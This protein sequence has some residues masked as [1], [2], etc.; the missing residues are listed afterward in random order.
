MRAPFC[1]LRFTVCGPIYRLSLI[2]HLEVDFIIYAE[3]LRISRKKISRW[4]I[5]RGCFA[6]SF[7]LLYQLIISFIFFFAFPFT[8]IPFV[9]LTTHIHTHIHTHT[10][11]RRSETIDILS[12][13]R[14]SLFLHS[15][16][17]NC[18]R[19]Y[20][21]TFSRTCV[22]VYMC[23]YMYAW[24]SKTYNG[25]RTYVQSSRYKKNN[26]VYYDLQC[27]LNLT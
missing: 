1:L 11:L 26:I 9:C 6:L 5:D 4:I 10:S 21:R 19:V 23:V 2:Y 13:K 17:V 22:C 16:R 25:M 15:P 12:L 18:W 7:A 8:I 3:W 24:V 27:C 20:V 14:F